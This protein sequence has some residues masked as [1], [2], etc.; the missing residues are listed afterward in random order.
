MRTGPSAK[1]RFDSASLPSGAR[2]AGCI[3]FPT[4]P[5]SVVFCCGWRKTMWHD[6]ARD[7]ATLAQKNGTV[8]D[9]Q[10]VLRHYR[11]ATTTE[12]YMQEIPE[13]VQATVNSIHSELR[14]NSAPR[15]AKGW[16]A[17]RRAQASVKSKQRIAAKKIPTEGQGKRGNSR[18]SETDS[19]Q[20]SVT[21]YEMLSN[22]RRECL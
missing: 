18:V 21:C 22:R 8:K 12:V 2:H 4:T 14:A 1:P 19:P 3:R 13:S 5:R 7:R 16:P 6:D 9:V 15:R 20:G 17:E 10:G 11:T